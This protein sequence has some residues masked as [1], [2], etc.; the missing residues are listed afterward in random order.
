M[1]LELKLPKNQWGEIVQTSEECPGVYHI[2]TQSPEQPSFR[3]FYAVLPEA[4][5]DIISEEALRYGTAVDGG[6]LF[7]YD[8][9]GNG[10]DI[11]TYELMRYHVKEGNLLGENQSLYSTAIYAAERYPDYFGGM[12]PPRVTP[13]GLTIRVKKAA[14]G[15]FFLETEGCHW[16]LAVANPIW[17]VD[18]SDYVVTLGEYCDDDQSMGEY[19]AQYLYFQRDLCAP[20]IYELLDRKEYQGLLAFVPSREVL[21]TKV[22]C[23]SPDYAV[24]HNAL[25]ISGQGRTDLLT[26]LLTVLNGVRECDS[27]STD[28]LTAL[29]NA[30]CVHFHPELADAELLLLP[31]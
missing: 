28:E 23:Q 20:A 22:Y 3:E 12:I 11:I 1:E 30:A 24:W 6:H 31:K 25:Q 21:E 26:N 19:E 17:D 18:L 5:P 29:R 10:W 2:A 27:R 7:E 14:E 8:A 13:W 4:V 9:K 16:V 15:I